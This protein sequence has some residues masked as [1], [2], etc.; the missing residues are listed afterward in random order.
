MIRT[1]LVA[2]LLG[3]TVVLGACSGGSTTTAEI[4]TTSGR[5]VSTAS[6]QSGPPP[7]APAHGYRAKHGGAELVYD[8][9]CGIYTVSGS[10]DTYYCDGSFYHIEYGTWTSSHNVTGPWTVV[11]KGKLPQGIQSMTTAKNG[12]GKKNQKL[13]RTTAN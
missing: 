6:T 1:I 4:T 9:S 3:A 10:S 12:K 7:H 13:Q 8:S 5:A 11:R 2:A